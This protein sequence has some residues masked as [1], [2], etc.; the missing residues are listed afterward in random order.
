MI[1]MFN[2]MLI[3]LQWALQIINRTYLNLVWEKKN[4]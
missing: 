3:L 4:P 1:L 2:L